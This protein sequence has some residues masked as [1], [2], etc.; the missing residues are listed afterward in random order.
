MSAEQNKAI[1]RQYL[2]D[3]RADTSPATLD[4]YIAEDELK[5][6]IAMYN[7]VLPGYYIV[8]DDLL[9]EG[10]RVFV[11]GMI[12]GVHRGAFGEIPPTGREVAFALY[13]VYRMAEGRIVEHW[14]LADMVAFTQQISA[15]EAA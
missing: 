5:Q 7:Q 6:H 14:M 3:L 11:R 2:E 10:D 4:R 12:H 15:V 13:I 1:I 8:A 9:A